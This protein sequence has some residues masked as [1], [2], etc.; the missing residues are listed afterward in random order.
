[1]TGRIGVLHVIT[2]LELGGAQRNTL[3]TVSHLDREAFA[4]ALAWGPGDRL[5]G[6]AF[7]LE[8]VALRPVGP[9]ARP[10]RPVADVRALVALRRVMRE[11]RPAIVHT[12]SSK[13]GI[14]GRLAAAMERVPAVVHSIHGFGF[15]PLQAAP[16]RGVFL[17]LE[18]LAARVTDHFIAVSRA[19]L[20]AGVEL[21]LFAPE[22]AS[23]IRSGIR[24]A[25]FAEPT[26]GRE[27]RRALG[28]PAGA[29][30]VTQVG[31]FK[32]QKAPLD[33]VRAAA[34]VGAAV[35]A[36]HF[37]LAGDGVLRPRIERLAAASGLGGRLH[38]PGWLDDVPAVLDA[39]DVA[40]LTSRHEGLPRAAV[41]AV[42][43]GVPV[44]AT[45]VDGTPEVVRDGENG[46]L[47]AP[48][49]VDGVA[50]AITRLLLDPALRRRLGSAPR[51]LGEFD[52]DFMVR[53]HEDLYRWLLGSK[54]S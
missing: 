51:E 12:H 13:A 16:V 29:P 43:A 18:R 52:I 10:V 35:P 46:F 1:M 49:D 8:G 39:S 25:R 33:F 41:E 45:A 28:V 5:D 42:A 6:E 7:A 30:L 36:A 14:L 3:Y 27:L 17:G 2:R 34:R 47:V 54:R 24:L 15:T 53:Q 21:G 20:R 4:P 37:L 32:P 38:L 44:V 22:R 26:G 31:N 23:V 48:G 19:N 11:L 50:A 9:L 40:V